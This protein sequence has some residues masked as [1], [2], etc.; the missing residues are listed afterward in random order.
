M[1]K[2]V[3]REVNQT[4]GDKLKIFQGHV[5]CNVRKYFFSKRVIHLWNSLPDS[6]IKSNI[7]VTARPR[8]YRPRPVRGTQLSGPQRRTI[9]TVIGRKAGA[10]VIFRDGRFYSNQYSGPN[11]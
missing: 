10:V 1:F 4:R 2:F 7:T 6:V 3:N 8:R 11:K 9:P 5:Y